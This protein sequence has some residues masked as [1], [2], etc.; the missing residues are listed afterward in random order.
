[1]LAGLGFSGS[2]FWASVRF[3]E[4]AF[5]SWTA[6]LGLRGCCVAI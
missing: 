1:L 3:R 2:G 5:G 6:W 4:G